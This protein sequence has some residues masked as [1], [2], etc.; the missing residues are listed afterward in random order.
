MPRVPDR[1]GPA[2]RAAQPAGTAVPPATP[3][4]RFRR[5]APHGSPPTDRFPRTGRDW[6]G[7]RAGFHGPRGAAVHRAG[8]APRA[9]G[10]PPSR[11]P[12]VRTAGPTI[13]PAQ[14]TRPATPSAAPPRRGPEARTGS[15]EWRRSP[16]TRTGNAEQ[17]PPAGDPGSRSRITRPRHGHRCPPQPGRPLRLRGCR[18]PEGDQSRC[19]AAAM[20]TAQRSIAAKF[21]TR[22]RIVSS[23]ACA[24][25]ASPAGRKMRRSTSRIIGRVG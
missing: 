9:L 5:S 16:E 6:P 24:R 1:A 21:C 7:P 17:P 13:P 23:R 22:S 12:P 19:R 18:P 14:H 10:R 3:G 2:A 20:V 25:S 8:I 11:P 15:T 4:R